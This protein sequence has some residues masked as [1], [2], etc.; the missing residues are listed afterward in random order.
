MVLHARQ[1][2]PSKTSIHKKRKHHS[3]IYSRSNMNMVKAEQGRTLQETNNGV[4]SARHIRDNVTEFGKATA[5]F[6]VVRNHFEMSMG[7]RDV[8][9]Y[10]R[11]G[12]EKPC[13]NKVSGAVIGNPDKVHLSIVLKDPELAKQYYSLNPSVFREKQKLLD[14]CNMK[15][16][17]TEVE[18]STS[19]SFISDTGN[20]YMPPDFCRVDQVDSEKMFKCNLDLRSD[21]I[22]PVVGYLLTPDTMMEVLDHYAEHVFYRMNMRDIL[23]LLRIMSRDSRIENKRSGEVVKEFGSASMMVRG[24]DNEL[25]NKPVITLVSNNNP[26]KVYPAYGIIKIYDQ[27]YEVEQPFVEDGSNGIPWS[28]LDRNMEKLIFSRPEFAQ[29]G[30][31]LISRLKLTVRI[32]TY[33]LFPRANKPVC[34]KDAKEVQALNLGSEKILHQVI[35]VSSTYVSNFPNTFRAGGK[36]V[37]VTTNRGYKFTVNKAAAHHFVPHHAFGASKGS[38]N[39]ACI[40]QHFGNGMPLQTEIQWHKD[41]PDQEQFSAS[42]WYSLI[43]KNIA[44]ETLAYGADRMVQAV[45]DYKLDHQKPIY[46]DHLDE[47]VAATNQE[48]MK[49][50]ALSW[51]KNFKDRQRK[52]ETHNGEQPYHYLSYAK[53]WFTCIVVANTRP[54]PFALVRALKVIF[55]VPQGHLSKSNTFVPDWDLIEPDP[56]TVDLVDDPKTPRGDAGQVLHSPRLWREARAPVP[57]FPPAASPPAAPPPA[58]DGDGMFENKYDALDSDDERDLHD[59]MMSASRPSLFDNEV[60]M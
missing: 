20:E 33:T 1:R 7:D 34:E 60:Y 55:Y 45:V 26:C 59:I 32:K 5:E 3:A 12:D 10:I 39:V 47:G 28:G 31:H 56:N 30:E 46:V 13:I 27:T 14:I 51:K 52:I 15:P 40:T 11:W 25:Q 53:P 22:P 35:E 16:K 19:F 54:S 38:N 21:M 8:H 23:T 24:S 9:G 4:I 42:S 41:D 37:F 50:F 29:K 2:P 57:V 18:Y 6:C 58:G 48:L 44:A 49:H 36:F 17:Y 43:N